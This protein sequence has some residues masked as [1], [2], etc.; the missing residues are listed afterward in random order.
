MKKLIV[1]VGRHT[2]AIFIAYGL[3]LPG[4]VICR[5]VRWVGLVVLHTFGKETVISGLAILAAFLLVLVV[6]VMVDHLFQ[7][8]WIVL[9]EGGA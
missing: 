7:N 2:A 4:M 8:L 3:I 5:A 1:H 6:P 9:V